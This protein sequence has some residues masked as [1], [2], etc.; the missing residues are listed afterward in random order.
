[1]ALVSPVGVPLENGIHTLKEVGPI[2]KRWIKLIDKLAEIWTLKWAEASQKEFRKKLRHSPREQARE[3]AEADSNYSSSDDF[4]LDDCDEGN[5]FVFRR[6]PRAD[7]SS[8]CFWWMRVQACPP[9]EVSDCLLQDEN[10]YFG[11]K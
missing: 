7:G 10:I 8:A 6:M 2:L 1:M 9:T 3:F 4:L 11:C 5:C